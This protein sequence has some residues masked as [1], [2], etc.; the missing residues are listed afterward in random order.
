M[1]LSLALLA[2]AV[3]VWVQWGERLR[4]KQEQLQA[5]RLKGVVCKHLAAV[6]EPE[7][8]AKHMR[9]ELKDHIHMMP[10]RPIDF[11]RIW[12]L[13]EQFVNEDSRVINFSKQVDCQMMEHWKWI[14][15][16]SPP[17]SPPSTTT[18]LRGLFDASFVACTTNGVAVA[19][20]ATSVP[21]DSFYSRPVPT[22]PHYKQ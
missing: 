5:E 18:T 19:L 1:L 15:R 17:S 13:V 11:D 12:P 4:A 8:V 9:D 6:S 16:K 14:G 21:A 3:W 20:P 2:G 22:A 7:I 10:H